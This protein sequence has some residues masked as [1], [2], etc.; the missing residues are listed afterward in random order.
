MKLATFTHGGRTR[1]GVVE[2]NEVIDVTVVAT[3]LPAGLKTLLA[4]GPPAF[5]AARTASASAPRLPLEQ[6]HLEAPVPNPGKFLAVGL[7]YA[8]HIREIGEKAP[9][10][11]SCFAKVG[12]CVNG[13]FD[14]VH[15]PRVS[16]T[17]DYEGELGFVI[18]R[19]C[20]HVP[21]ERAAEVI[22]GYVVVDDFTVRKWVALTPQVV[23]PKSF[24]THGPFGPWLVTADEVGDPHRLAIRTWVNDEL[25]QD[26]DTGQMIFG[27]FDLVA[28]LSSAVTLEPGDVIATGTPYGVGE[29]LVPR[30]YL[31]PGDVVK[32]EVEGLGHIANP[33]VDEPADTAVM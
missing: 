27:C 15:R 5:D 7:N 14:P 25:R 1:F 20:R 13:P 31:Q 33:I 32:V 29:G 23:I 16:H 24:D 22:A 28:Y 12:T 3:E 10:N 6:V 8:D 2:A 26:S 9:R 17:L 18:G 11:P 21:K 19:R 4:L 30:R